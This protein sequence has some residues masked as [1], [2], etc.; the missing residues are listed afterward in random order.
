LRIALDAFG[1][2]DGNDA[3]INIDGI[4]ILSWNILKMRLFL[5]LY[6]I[7]DGMKKMISFLNEKGVGTGIHYIPHYLPP[8]FKPYP[9]DLRVIEKIT[10]SYLRFRYATA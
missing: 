8:F 10:M 5:A 4:N 9:V 1:I 7:I 3:F 6:R 2:K